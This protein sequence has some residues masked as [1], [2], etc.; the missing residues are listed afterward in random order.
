MDHGKASNDA[1]HSLSTVAHTAQTDD[2]SVANQVNQSLVF[3][4]SDSEKNSMDTIH[5]T[6]RTEHDG[7][8]T[9]NASSNWHNF[10][11]MKR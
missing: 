11:N 6:E 5:T 8:I 2:A 3:D 7:A 9:A 1:N 4:Y 10:H